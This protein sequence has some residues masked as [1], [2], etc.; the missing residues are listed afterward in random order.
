MSRLDDV[1]RFYDLLGELEE[2]FGGKRTLVECTGRMD[3]PE[4]GVYF[5][6][7][8]G[9]VRSESG[10]GLR[11]VRVGTHAVS[12]GSQSTLWKRLSNHRNGNNRTS[13]FRMLI[14][15]AISVADPVLACSSWGIPGTPHRD[16]RDE[17]APLERKVSERL[18]GM[19][20]LYLAADDAPSFQSIRAV[21]ER[22][23]IALLNNH[24]RAVKDIVDPPSP[25][26]LGRSSPR[27]KVRRSGLWNKDHVDRIVWDPDFM[28]RFEALVRRQ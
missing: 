21:V 7:E 14:G 27:E 15:E 10:E 3:W 23:S 18:W 20:F 13:D 16:I 22:N 17:E 26:W 11:I 8:P 25:G 2:R 28:A 4:R 19:P 6:F 1:R 12:A 9:E 24:G 5:F